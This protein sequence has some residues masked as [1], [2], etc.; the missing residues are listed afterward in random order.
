[1]DDHVFDIDWS[2]VD[3]H[4]RVRFIGELDMAAVEQTHDEAIE[5]LDG[6]AGPVVIDLTGLTFCDASGIRLL[7]QLDAETK[8]RG[9]TMVLLHPTPF[10]SRVFDA[11]GISESLTIKD[12]RCG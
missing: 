9:R 10:L 5:V 1:M 11:A 7:L 4:A 12:G 3:G 2:Q 8:G 6:T